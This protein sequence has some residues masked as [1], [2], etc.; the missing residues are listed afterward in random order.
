M[1]EDR[2]VG[3]RLLCHRLG[4]RRRRRLHPSASALERGWIERERND[5]MN[6]Q[7]DSSGQSLAG[8]LFPYVLFY[9]FTF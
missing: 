8:F 4:R 1:A 5:G 9:L 3:R 2:I 7:L 6:G